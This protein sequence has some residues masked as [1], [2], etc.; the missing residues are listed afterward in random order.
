MSLSYTKTT[1]VD[2]DNKYDIQ[3]QGSVQI[4]G[5][6]KLVYVGTAAGT[7]IS[8]TVMNNIE[9]AIESIVEYVNVTEKST[10]QIAMGGWNF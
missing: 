9:N 2:G 3:T 6:I 10:F 7:A 1:W 5:N 4:Y 8:A